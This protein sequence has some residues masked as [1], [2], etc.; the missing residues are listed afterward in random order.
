MFRNRVRH[1][2][3]L[4]FGHTVCST[5]CLTMFR[6]C[7]VFYY[8]STTLYVRLCFDQTLYSTLCLTLFRQRYVHNYS[9]IIQ[10]LFGFEYVLTI[11]CIWSKLSCVEP[12]RHSCFRICVG[13]KRLFLTTSFGSSKI[14]VRHR[15]QSKH[16]S[17]TSTM[18]IITQNW[19]VYCTIVKLYNMQLCFA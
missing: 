7:Y 11:L 3:R 12:K 19:I 1:Y 5:L 2:L 10:P 14:R 9:I 17:K 4:C 16:K 13:P 6:L 8:S 18:D 15:V